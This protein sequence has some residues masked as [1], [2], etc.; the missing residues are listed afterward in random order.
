MSC[1]Y[2]KR[3]SSNFSD[4]CAV[5]GSVTGHDAKKP[6]STGLCRRSEW[7]ATGE[8]WNSGG[9]S[10]VHSRASTRNTTTRWRNIS[11]RSTTCAWRSADVCLLMT[12][13]SLRRFNRISVYLILC[14]TFMWFV[15]N[16]FYCRIFV[17][18]TCLVM[19]FLSKCDAVKHI[20]TLF[21]AYVNF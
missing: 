18:V 12:T 9:P 20:W 16:F 3:R 11:V 13:V 19:F 15:F 5:D 7:S 21:E 14:Y 6:T 4:L 2:K 17:K 10:S 8:R 1:V